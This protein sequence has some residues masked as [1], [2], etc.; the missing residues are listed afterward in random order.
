MRDKDLFPWPTEQNN[1]IL[2]RGRKPT[3]DGLRVQRNDL[4]W[5]GIEFDKDVDRLVIF[6]A[7]EQRDRIQ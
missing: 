4:R 1:P 2:L 5:I 6:S 7:L 3:G